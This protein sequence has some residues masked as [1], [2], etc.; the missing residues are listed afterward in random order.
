[1]IQ[2][3]RQS[4]VVTPSVPLWVSEL[5]ADFKRALPKPL[6]F[7]GRQLPIH[8]DLRRGMGDIVEPLA[9]G[10]AGGAQHVFRADP[11]FPRDN[12]HPMWACAAVSWPRPHRPPRRADMAIGATWMRGDLID[13]I[14]GGKA[15]FLAGEGRG[16]D[17]YI[18]SVSGLGD[19]A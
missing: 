12:V 1:M 16:L 19:G 4:E 15:V 13:P 17:Y 9:V 5:F 10:V 18:F 7:S 6:C 3:A 11:A 2:V 8:G 14:P